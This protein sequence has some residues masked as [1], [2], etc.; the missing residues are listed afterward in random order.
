[1]AKLW[2]VEPTEP[3]AS[4]DGSYIFDDARLTTYITYCIA[5]HIS[6]GEIMSIKEEAKITTLPPSILHWITYE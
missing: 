5:K 6:F 2:I 3:L 1:M 4:S